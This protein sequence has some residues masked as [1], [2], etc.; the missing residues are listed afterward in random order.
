LYFRQGEYKGSKDYKGSAFVRNIQ[1]ALD[2]KDAAV[3]VQQLQGV[4]IFWVFGIA[5]SI[6]A[7]ALELFLHT[8]KKC[9]FE[10][11]EARKVQ[12]PPYFYLK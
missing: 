6:L 1:L 4:F 7:F 10:W 3:S 8:F 12:V 11:M 5:S 9:K 2:Q